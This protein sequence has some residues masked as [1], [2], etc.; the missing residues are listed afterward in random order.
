MV[1]KQ[2]ARVYRTFGLISNGRRKGKKCVSHFCL[3]WDVYTESDFFRYNMMPIHPATHPCMEHKYTFQ[4]ENQSS[5]CK[6]MVRVMCTYASS[7][8]ECKWKWKWILAI[9]WSSLPCRIIFLAHVFFSHSIYL[10]FY[11]FEL[12]RLHFVCIQCHLF[13]GFPSIQLPYL[14]LLYRPK[15]IHHHP[16]SIEFYRLLY[17]HRNIHYYYLLVHKFK[18]FYRLFLL[19]QSVSFFHSSIFAVVRQLHWPFH[20]QTFQFKWLHWMSMTFLLISK[21]WKHLKCKCMQFTVNWSVTHQRISRI[22]D[23]PYVHLK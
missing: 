18:Y 2:T 9:L 20:T 21:S 19:C 10:P 17:G 16:P 1:N 4:I 6:C 11:L 7:A 3:A 5:L 13:F 8:W 14:L 15:T 22:S 12:L 23:K